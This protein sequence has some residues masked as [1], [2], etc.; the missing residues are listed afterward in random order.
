VE[1]LNPCC[2]NSLRLI[3]AIFLKYI[4]EFMVS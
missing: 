1:A 3:L 2:N 4:F